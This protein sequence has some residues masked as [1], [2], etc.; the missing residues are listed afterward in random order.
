MKRVRFVKMKMAMAMMR[1]AVATRTQGSKSPS[2]I[3]NRNDWLLIKWTK[4]YGIPGITP[5]GVFNTLC[6]DGTMDE[7]LTG[8]EEA[9]M[10]NAWA[11]VGWAGMSPGEL[12][13]VFTYITILLTLGD[14]A[15]E[16]G[17]LTQSQSEVFWSYRQT[18]IYYAADSLV[19]KTVVDISRMVRVC[20]TSLTP[21]KREIE[22]GGKS[23]RMAYGPRR[24][25]SL[26][27]TRMPERNKWLSACAVTVIARVII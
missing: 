2:I 8:V 19:H 14:L 17:I 5:M 1:V 10:P 26:P 22:G 4:E 21:K 12:V 20:I 25:H 9:A 27:S 11:D 23:S 13:C 24:R 7:W 6:L 3:P 15:V 18:M 16:T